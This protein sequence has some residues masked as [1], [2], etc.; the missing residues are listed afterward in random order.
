MRI[1]DWSSDVCSSDLLYRILKQADRSRQWALWQWPGSPV[2]WGASVDIFHFDR[3]TRHALRQGGCHEWIKRAIEHVI[4][5]S[6]N[7]AGAQILHHLIGLTHIGADLVAPSNVGFRLVS[8]LRLCFATLRFSL[9]REGFQTVHCFGI[10][11]SEER[12]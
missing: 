6:R 1:S 7:D 8:R 3:L 5:R 12:H 2:P 11:C 9:V 4:R 10:Y